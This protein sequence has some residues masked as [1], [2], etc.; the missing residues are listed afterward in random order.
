MEHDRFI[1]VATD[2]IWDFVSNEEAVAIVAA[3]DAP[4]E[5]ATALARE[6]FRRWKQRNDGEIIDDITVLVASLRNIESRSVAGSSRRSSLD[7]HSRLSSSSSFG[8]QR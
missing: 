4:E 8:S 2:G 1:V 6:A 7:R 5:A 3:C